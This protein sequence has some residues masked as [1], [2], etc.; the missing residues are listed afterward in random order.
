[1]ACVY[2]LTGSIGMGKSAVAGMIRKLGVPLFD[3]DAEVHRLQGPGGIALEV[4]EA[5]FPGTTGPLGLDRAKLAAIILA[6]P[7]ERKALEAIIH[8][9][10]FAARQ[11]FLRRHVS[12]PLVVLDIPLLFETHG[13]KRVDGV[14]VVTAPAW[15]QR[16][17]VL[18]RP[19]MTERKFRAIL[20]LQMPDMQKRRRADHLVHTGTTYHRTRAQV[21]ALM[22]CLLAQAGR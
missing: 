10:V 3:A 21:R 5:R 7:H 4:I 15:K 20:R 17:R 22:A 14:I 6:H 13:E 2:A 1:M 12:R 18:A 11:E 16:K 9:L 8:P 19:G